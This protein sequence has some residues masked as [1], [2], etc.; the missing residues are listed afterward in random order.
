MLHSSLLGCPSLSWMQKQKLG[1]KKTLT[2]II[3]ISSTRL[4]NSKTLNM[5]LRKKITIWKKLKTKKNP[6]TYL[7]GGITNNSQDGYLRTKPYL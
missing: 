2:Q 3:R 6:I 4:I 5:F 1:T 7:L